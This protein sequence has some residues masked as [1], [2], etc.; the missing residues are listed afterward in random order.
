MD[1]AITL[2]VTN[3]NLINQINLN[4]KINYIAI[5]PHRIVYGSKIMYIE[6]VEV[7]EVYKTRETEFFIR[8]ASDIEAL[9]SKIDNRKG[10]LYLYLIFN[11]EKLTVSSIAQIIENISMYILTTK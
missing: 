10:Y 3:S 7:R 2:M 1:K 8:E 5:Y 11:E 9:F 6:G 4:S